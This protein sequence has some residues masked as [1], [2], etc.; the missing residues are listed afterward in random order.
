MAG[1]HTF[2]TNDVVTAT[3]LN[4]YV[5]DNT[6]PQVTSATRPTGVQGQIIYESDTGYLQIYSGSGWVRFGGHAGWTSYTPTLTQSATVTK[7]VSYAKYEKIGRLVY[8][9][10]SLS[11]TGAGTV[12]NAIII[13]VPFTAGTALINGS[14]YLADTSAGTNYPFIVVQASTTTVTLLD[15]TQGTGGVF[16]GQTGA[17]MSAALAS[18]DGIQCSFFYEAAA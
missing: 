12:N 5:R 13:G 11:I 2:A 7:T 1:S 18:G 6:I 10:I 4:N 17:A 8:V 3:D 16:L 9:Q 15:S 14:G